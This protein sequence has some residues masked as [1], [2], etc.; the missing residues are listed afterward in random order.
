[1]KQI[2]GLVSHKSDKNYG[3]KINNTWYNFKPDEYQ[4]F[5]QTV[6]LKFP[7]RLTV[8]DDRNVIQWESLKD[9]LRGNTEE[10][11]TGSNE[12]V[13]TEI[14]ETDMPQKETTIDTTEETALTKQTDSKVE[15]VDI[16]KQRIELEKEKQ[17][18][19]R[20]QVLFK[21]AIDLVCKLIET[22]E[23]K[24]RPPREYADVVVEV[25]KV[26]VEKIE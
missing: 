10:Q 19:I 23:I 22:R 5:I 20:K 15:Y 21:G 8:D 16:Q 7:V 14:D 9:Y 2:L 17:I 11:T 18:D 3:V 26:F 13:D 12:S 4:K 24:T 25:Y 1:M 6:D